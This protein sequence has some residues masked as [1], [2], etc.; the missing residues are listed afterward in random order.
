M[1]VWFGVLALKRGGSM[2]ERVYAYL[3]RVVQERGAGFLPIL[4]PDR[5]TPT[6]AADA[7]AKMENAGADALL[8]GTSLM[9]AATFEDTIQQIKAKTDI[10]LV[11]F[12][13]SSAQI[14]RL[15]DAMLLPSLISGRNP[16]FLIGQHVQAAWRL[17]QSGLETIPMGYMLVESG[18]TTSVEFMSG[19][20]PIPRNKPEIAVA[21]ALAGQ[22]LGLKML[23]LE[24]GSGALKPVPDE[25]IAAVRESIDV[26]LIVGGGIRAPDVA[27][28]KVAA[29]ADLIVVGSALEMNESGNLMRG[30]A[31][32][33]HAG[34]RV[35]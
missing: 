7:A 8:I 9:L 19:T 14:S 2:S 10:P 1:G 11:I 25:M 18:T 32:A 13:G 21:H 28:Q 6:G 12:P 5:L 4:D 3:Q 31:R 33:V 29:G 23:F 20:K 35:E 27:G 22:L 15:A 30:F 34:T 16:E 24:A 26:P 17:K